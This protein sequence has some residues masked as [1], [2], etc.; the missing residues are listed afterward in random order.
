M[1]IPPQP[2][3]ALMH[4]RSAIVFKPEVNQLSQ[5]W[6]HFSVVMR[7]LAEV[8]QQPFLA[9]CCGLCVADYVIGDA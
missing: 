2:L 7:E 9:D 6:N 3:K 8:T 1:H 4:G 5:P